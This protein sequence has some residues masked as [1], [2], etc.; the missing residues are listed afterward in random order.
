MACWGG[1]LK[2]QKCLIFHRP[3]VTL[4]H[5]SA[6]LETGLVCLRH[7]IVTSLLVL[8]C[9]CLVRKHLPACDGP[10]SEHH[11]TTGPR[12]KL[13]VLESKPACCKHRQADLVTSCQHGKY[14]RLWSLSWLDHSRTSREHTRTSCKENRHGC[15]RKMQLGNVQDRPASCYWPTAC[16]YA[17]CLYKV[18]RFAKRIIWIFNFDALTWQCSHRL[19]FFFYKLT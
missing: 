10:V 2:Y 9:Y 7:V 19:L 6:H 3:S 18:S 14:P 5:S 12:P 11:S 4:D 13:T 8:N 16:T 1:S 15:Y 17:I